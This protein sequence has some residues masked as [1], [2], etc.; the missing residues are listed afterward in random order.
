MQLLVQRTAAAVLKGE[1]NEDSSIELKRDYPDDHHK[2]A[3]HVAGHANS[4][5]GGD[6]VW[7]IG[8][9]EG[10]NGSAGRLH[11]PRAEE[12]SSYW[13]RVNA[14]F[15]EATP[16]LYLN[17]VVPIDGPEGSVNLVALAFHTAEAPYVVT[18]PRHGNTS[19]ESIS[20]EVPWRKGSNQVE[21]ARRRDLLELLVPQV[22]IPG[23]DFIDGKIERGKVVPGHDGVPVMLTLGLYLIPHMSGIWL[24]F[25]RC[26][27]C[28]RIP[29][30]AHIALDEVQMEA[31]YAE[32]YA[33][34]GKDALWGPVRRQSTSISIHVGPEE[35]RADGPGRVNLKKQIWVSEAEWTTL[36]DA[37]EM[38][39]E[40][41]IPVSHVE[42]PLR[43]AGTLRR[44]S[45]TAQ[46]FLPV[47][48]T[49]AK[50][51]PER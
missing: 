12:L 39:V 35:L 4:A 23:C 41:G 2:M 3:R 10:K 9:Q 1:R 33:G 32:E 49:S 21:T 28:V 29:R 14:N 8:L 17:V 30:A 5:R 46:L 38:R 36:R 50:L 24:L 25:F 51:Q 22:R 7:I 40:L 43:V 16:E 37:T 13:S 42:L 27:G 19:G 20:L 31:P 47:L 44:A 6:I 11:P 34:D 26:N 18:N 48:P 45:A 15:R